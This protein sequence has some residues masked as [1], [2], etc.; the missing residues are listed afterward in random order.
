MAA[1]EIRIVEADVSHTDR[2]APLFD[3]YRVFYKQPSD[4]ELAARFIRDRLS[5][6]DS[7]I[8]LAVNAA[9]QDVGFVQLYPTF[10]SVA[11][12]STWILNDLFVL[13]ELRGEGIG[14]VLLERSRQLAI[15]T[16]ARG[17]TLSTAR[18]NARAQGLYESFGFKR[19]TH[20]YQ[21]F[22]AT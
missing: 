19:D 9:D 15:D 10:S 2:I 17:L 4:L 7:T 5:A 20:F 11:A 13:P 12:R 3:Q 16:G 14:R 21:Y 8:Y 6:G 22:L 18:D 1:S